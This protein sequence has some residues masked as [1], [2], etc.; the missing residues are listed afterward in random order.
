[1]EE[2]TLNYELSKEQASK[3]KIVKVNILSSWCYNLPNNID[4]TICRCN[5]NCD[6]IY[7]QE[8]GVES[9]VVTGLCGHSFHYDC[10]EPW[11]KTSN[12]CP[13]CSIKWSYKK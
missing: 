12:Y 8:K 5:L 9:Y 7:A 2:K 6:S 4:C 10:I 3:F 1:M 11:I 13:I